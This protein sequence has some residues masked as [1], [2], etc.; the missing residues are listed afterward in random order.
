MRNL[1][2]MNS[3]TRGNKIGVMGSLSVS[4]PS[5]LSRKTRGSPRRVKQGG[6]KKSFGINNW[7]SLGMGEK[8]CSK[9]KN[10]GKILGLLSGEKR[11]AFLAIGV[12]KMYG[13]KAAEK[14]RIGKI[15]QKLNAKCFCLRKLFWDTP[16]YH[17]E[18]WTRVVI[19]GRA[20]ERRAELAEGAGHIRGTKG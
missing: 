8:S 18:E 13:R 12:A 14:R 6:S 19:R 15:F 7:H 20:W 9:K 16:V 5:T 17:V 10:R 11:R 3:G 1:M 4:T 2:F